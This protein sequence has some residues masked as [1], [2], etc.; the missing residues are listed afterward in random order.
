[1]A[2]ILIDNLRFD[3]WEA[4]SKFFYNDFNIESDLYLSILPTTT[5]YARNALLR[6]DASE[7]ERFP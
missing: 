6:F 2:L 7:I 4:I 5:S 1:M 3:H